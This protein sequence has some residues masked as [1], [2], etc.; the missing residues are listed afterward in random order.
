MPGKGVLLSACHGR[1]RTLQRTA[2]VSCCRGRV[3]SFDCRMAGLAHA[4]LAQAAAR[5]NAEGLRTH[6]GKTWTA[7]NLRKFMKDL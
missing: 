1:F 2:R 7:D 5:L 6:T 3:A 4:T